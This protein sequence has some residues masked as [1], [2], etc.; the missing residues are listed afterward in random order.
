MN[1]LY[2]DLTLTGISRFPA[3]IS[4]R[5]RDRENDG[6]DIYIFEEFGQ[7]ETVEVRKKLP[8]GAQLIHQSPVRIDAIEQLI[9]EYQIDRV[10]IFAQRIPDLCVTAAARRQNIPVHMLQHG[11]YVQ[12]MVREP[13]FLW[14]RLAKTVRFIRHAI[15]LARELDISKRRAIRGFA[16]HYLHGKTLPEALPESI[17]LLADQVYTYADYWTE[18][19]HQ[20]YGYPL[21][22]CVKIGYPDLFHYHELKTHIQESACCYIAQTLVED[23][24]LERPLMIDF[25]ERLKT[26]CPTDLALLI[27]LHPRSD[28]NMYEAIFHDRPGTRLVEE[29]PHC[30]HYAGHYSSL[31]AL[32]YLCSDR[33]LLWHFDN[34]RIPDYFLQNARS[35]PAFDNSDIRAFFDGDIY[36]PETEID[37]QQVFYLN[38]IDPIDDL[39]HHL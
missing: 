20:I 39:I 31:L 32:S 22:R 18:Y 23:G 33:V 28:R 4:S 15:H 17:T 30:T 16:S 11:L 26:E 14:K 25:L 5:F 12:H 35:F 3:R 38:Q 37:I 6:Q 8:K 13:G 1:I 21:K 27:K 7:M 34:H 24:R 19:H 36:T 9:Q 2:F 10:M 29:F